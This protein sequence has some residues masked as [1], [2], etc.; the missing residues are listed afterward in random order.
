M[1][2]QN[3]HGAEI[4][5]PLSCKSSCPIP[6]PKYGGTNLQPFPSV[7]RCYGNVAQCRKCANTLAG[8]RSLSPSLSPYLSPDI[9]LYISLSRSLSLSLS[10]SLSPFSH[11]PQHLPR[12]LCLIFGNPKIERLCRLAQTRRSQILHKA[13]KIEMPRVFW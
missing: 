8:A 5:A 6:S 4:G 1:Q 9:T 11:Q 12:V 10:L 7:T 3:T 13:K 2:H